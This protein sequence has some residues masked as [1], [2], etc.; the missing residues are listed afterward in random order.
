ML[1]PLTPTRAAVLANAP[2]PLR[3]ARR[4]GATCRLLHGWL[5]HRYGGH[6]ARRDRLGVIRGHAT[7]WN[8]ARGT[9]ID[10]DIG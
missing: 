5:E 10:S 3:L 6:A 9:H 8:S 1:C 4:H 7:D 2:A